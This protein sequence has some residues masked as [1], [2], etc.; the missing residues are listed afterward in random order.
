MITKLQTVYKSWIMF[1]KFLIKLCESAVS[2][3]LWF[4]QVLFTESLK[5]KFEKSDRYLFSPENLFTVLK[6]GSITLN[7]RF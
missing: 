1:E 7:K 3:N 4:N 6:K 2:F 5:L